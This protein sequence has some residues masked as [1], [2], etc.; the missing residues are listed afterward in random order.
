MMRSAMQVSKECDLQTV[1]HTGNTAEDLPYYCFYF[2]FCR[3]EVDD[4][5]HNKIILYSG[6]NQNLAVAERT[7]FHDILHDKS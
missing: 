7:Y 1:D 4:G 5:V 6:K 2:P 3:V